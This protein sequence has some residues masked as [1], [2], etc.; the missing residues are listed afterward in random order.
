MTLTKDDFG[1]KKVSGV[2]EA[3]DIL[4]FLTSTVMKQLISFMQ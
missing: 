1:Y 4:Y 2:P 3:I